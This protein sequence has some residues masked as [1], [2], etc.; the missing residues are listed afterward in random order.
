MIAL[1]CHPRIG[2]PLKAH[3]QIFDHAACLP[4]PRNSWHDPQSAV[5]SRLMRE[6]WGHLRP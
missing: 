4:S 5:G 1:A 6:P 3:R 2:E